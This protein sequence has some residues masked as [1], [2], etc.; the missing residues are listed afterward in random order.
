MSGVEPAQALARLGSTVIV[1]ARS[2]PVN[3]FSTPATQF[4]EG[5]L[6]I[7]GMGLRLTTQV[8]RSVRADAGPHRVTLDDGTPF[9]ADQLLFP[10]CSGPRLGRPWSGIGWIVAEYI[11]ARTDGMD[12]G[13]D[14]GW[15]DA[16]GGAAGKYCLTL[17][18][19]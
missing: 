19:K 9:V 17:L 13:V 2:S 10:I 12:T 5:T 4:L 15:S 8:T 6:S 18:G 14:G 7:E 16:V 3:A 11:D 1:V